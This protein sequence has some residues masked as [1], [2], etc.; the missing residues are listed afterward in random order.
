MGLFENGKPLVIFGNGR[1]T[2]EGGFAVR[3]INKT[4]APSV[5]GHILEAEGTTDNGVE[6]AGINDPDP[7]GIMY[8]N[9]VPDGGGC[10]MVVSGIAEVLYG[11]VVTR[12][13]FSRV[14]VTADGIAAGLAV[15]EALPAPPFSTDKHFMEIGHPIESIGAPG[16][17]KTVLHFN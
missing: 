1:L 10:W 3:V 6:K 11:T 5:K 8:D 12:A 9:G 13:T 2:K 15:N 16:L 7:F 4:G 17:A 14:P